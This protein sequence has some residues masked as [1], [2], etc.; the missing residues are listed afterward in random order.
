MCASDQWPKWACRCA[1]KKMGYYA[2]A[3]GLSAVYEIYYTASN[4][5]AE[6]RQPAAAIEPQSCRTT[7]T[8]EL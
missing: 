5:V 7:L 6:R 8:R 3:G 4:A 2:N 1:P